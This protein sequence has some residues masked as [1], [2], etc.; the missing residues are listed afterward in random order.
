MKIFAVYLRLNLI[1]KPEWFDE[2]RSKYDEPLELHVT[3]IQPRYIAEE[4][5]D[6]ISASLATFLDKE[7]M[8]SI[9]KMISFDQLVYEQEHDGTYT[10]MLIA[11]MADELHN[12]QKKLRDT[13]REFTEYVDKATIEYE[14]NFRPHITIARNIHS[15][16]LP[17]VLAHFQSD[18]LVKGVLTKLVLPI[19]KDTS[20][21][22]RKNPSNQ[23]AFDL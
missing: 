18:F 6:D 8:S 19:V 20:V 12:F 4:K 3:L 16:Y 2:F 13:L 17:E 21:E 5:V 9:N 10:L 1:Q 7:K 14:K 11:Q 22:E 15:T 23:Q